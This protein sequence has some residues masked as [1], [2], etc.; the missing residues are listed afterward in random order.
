MTKTEVV[1]QENVKCNHLI[2][3]RTYKLT[4]EHGPLLQQSGFV[5]LSLFFPFFSF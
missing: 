5:F 4:Y 3:Y 2:N 1:S